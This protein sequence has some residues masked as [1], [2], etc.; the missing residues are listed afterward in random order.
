MPRVRIIPKK[1]R[2]QAE[3]ALG[4]KT[5]KDVAGTGPVTWEPGRGGA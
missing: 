3:L 5:W 2:S 1:D 4:M